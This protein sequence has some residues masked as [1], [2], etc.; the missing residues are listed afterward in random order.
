MLE[1]GCFSLL[2]PMILDINPDSEYFDPESMSA[3]TTIYGVSK[4]EPHNIYAAQLE[5][6]YGRCKRRSGMF[7][8]TVDYDMRQILPG[9]KSKTY[10]NIST[11]FSAT[12]GK[13][14]DYLAFYWDKNLMLDGR[15]ID[16]VGA[17]VADES[18]LS[19]STFQTI[20]AFERLSY[21]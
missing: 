8:A 7:N 15:S 19:N 2:F 18:V 12:V 11:F 17:K 16:H 20:N 21:D 3:N 1:Q 6:G 14:E 9:L 13:K 10:I 5:G 4:D